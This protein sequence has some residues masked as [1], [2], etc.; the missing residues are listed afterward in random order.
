MSALDE[1]IAIADSVEGEDQHTGVALDARAEL[2]QLRAT[3]AEQAR[4]LAE[5]ERPIGKAK[6]QLYYPTSRSQPHII[7]VDD[8]GDRVRYVAEFYHEED[9]K[10]FIDALNR[11]AHPAP[12]TAP[13]NAPRHFDMCPCVA[14][15]H[16][17]KP[18]SNGCWHFTPDGGHQCVNC[19]QPSAPK[20]DEAQ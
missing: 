2:A 3:V 12:Q 19:G 4:Q 15:E 18:C 13:K 20:P 11:A 8:H 17:V 6:Y 14:A 5:Q 7:E 9:A 10:E 16:P 1:C